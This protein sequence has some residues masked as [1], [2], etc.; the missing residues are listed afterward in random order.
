[1]IASGEALA[2]H[3]RQQLLQKYP[4]ADLDGN[5]KID[6]GEAKA[7]AAKLQTAKVR[8]ESVKKPNQ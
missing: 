2:R 6:A 7:L 4:Q 5:G 3:R 8:V 1:M